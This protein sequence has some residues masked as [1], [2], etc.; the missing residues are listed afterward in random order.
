M[1][2]NN[3][4]LAVFV[5]TVLCAGVTAAAQPINWSF[6]A[7][8]LHATE[9]DED[10][11]TWDEDIINITVTEPGVLNIDAE[12]TDIKGKSGSE[13]LCGGGSRTLVGGW[14]GPTDRGVSI[15][16]RAGDYVLKLNP[17][18][19]TSVN[20]RVRAELLDA[21]A[22]ESGDDHG[23][24]P[25]CATEL[26]SGTSANGS[27]GSYTDP[28]Y[29]YFSFAITSAA[30]VDVDSSG[31]TDVAGD[32]FDENGVLLASDGESTT[33][34]SISESLTPGRYVVRVRPVGT[35]TGS[36]SVLYE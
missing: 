31:S 1:L 30:T 10:I 8:S 36:Y 21:C 17:H 3:L 25:V 32:L 20:H 2:R 11:D 29:D 26:C 14:F 18:G 22:G 6:S 13:D 33:N 16:V 4:R 24:I 9:S 7:S 34:F 35:A 15:P 19:T 23:D 5:L 12:G 28:D 27:I